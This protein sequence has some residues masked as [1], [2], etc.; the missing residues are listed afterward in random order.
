MDEEERVVHV[1]IEEEEEAVRTEY[2][3]FEDVL[4]ILYLACMT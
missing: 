1:N 2:M 3:R 4:C